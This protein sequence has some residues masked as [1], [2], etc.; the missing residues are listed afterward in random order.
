VRS[1]LLLG[2]EEEERE[3]GSIPPETAWSDM[4]N[5]ALMLDPQNEYEVFAQ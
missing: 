1:L 4:G 5:D 2:R 3:P